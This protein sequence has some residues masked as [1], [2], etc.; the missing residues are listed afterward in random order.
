MEAQCG[1]RPADLALGATPAEVHQIIEQ[2]PGQPRPPRRQ[3]G[4]RAVELW[5]TLV[6]SQAIA[7]T[8]RCLLETMVAWRR[9]PLL[10]CRAGLPAAC[11]GRLLRMGAD[12]DYLV[13]GPFG[14][15]SIWRGQNTWSS[16]L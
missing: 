4:G 7:M 15:Q 2:P 10:V 6:L 8:H 9:S 16:S 13:F 12:N 11:A 5:S 14:L 3:I 1:V